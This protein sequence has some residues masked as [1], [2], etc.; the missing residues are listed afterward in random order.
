MDADI[1]YAQSLADEEV[2]HAK[3][4]AAAAKAAADEAAN[5]VPYVQ[6]PFIFVHDA[7]VFRGRCWIAYLVI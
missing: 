1:A 6:C 2:E 3:Q 4:V 5:E 7:G